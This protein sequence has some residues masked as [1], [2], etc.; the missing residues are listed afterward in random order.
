MCPDQQ[1]SIHVLIADGLAWRQIANVSLL[2]NEKKR[3]LR[4]LIRQKD[5]EVLAICY[6]SV[7]KDCT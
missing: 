5:E 1:Q 6:S 4:K 3:L 2:C 7:G